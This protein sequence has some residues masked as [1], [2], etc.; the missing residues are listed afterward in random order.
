MWVVIASRVA[1]APVVLSQLEPA[2]SAL[3]EGHYELAFALL[4]GAA[5]EPVSPQARGWYRLHLAAADALYGPAGVEH[6]LLALREAAREEPD[7][8]H[9]PLYRALHWEFRALQGAKAEEVRRGLASLQHDDSLASYHAASALWWAGS[10]RSAKRVLLALPEQDLPL[11]LRWRRWSLLG[12]AHAELGDAEAAA[13][14]F[15]VAY[16]ET[17]D[18]ERPVVALHLA[19]ALL[20][21][22]R[23]MEAQHLLGYEPLERLSQEDQGWWFEVS[24]RVEYDLGNPERALDR[25][26]EALQHVEDPVR[27][28]D[29]ERE[30]AHA[31]TALG[32]PREAAVR[33]GAI[34]AEVPGDERTTVL[35]E[36]AVAWI[37]AEDAEEGARVLRD[38]LLDPDYPYR[39]EATADLADCDFRRGDFVSA[40]ETALRALEAG[41]TGPACLTLGAVAFEYF[42]LVEATEWLEQAITASSEGDAT[43]LTAQSVLSDVFAQRGEAFAERLLQHAKAALAHCEPGSDWVGPLEAHVEQAKAWLLGQDRWLN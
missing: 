13:E 21:S 24:G 32:R 35:H 37:D 16:D 17:T 5:D 31:L 2:Q 7:L 8:V 43:W 15:T 6:G 1:T 30:C 42:D 10:A 28:A 27:R 23:P 14:A 34:L 18:V 11:Y 33:L 19:H 36:Q 40:R 29:I 26:T 9:S 38:V 20:D 12:H 41:A 4:E 3:A 39:A 22:G 25:F